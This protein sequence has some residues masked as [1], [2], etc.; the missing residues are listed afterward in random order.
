MERPVN[1][2]RE[3]YQ[4][5]KDSFR[6]ARFTG[7]WC[8]WFLARAVLGI[9]IIVGVFSTWYFGLAL[10]AICYCLLLVVRRF[11]RCPRCG[12]AWSSEELE[13]FVCSG[14]RLNI[15]L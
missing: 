6:L 1:P 7:G 2:D 4:K 9:A 8:G 13:S 3:E 5:I 15:G 11:S 10:F 12:L 14:C